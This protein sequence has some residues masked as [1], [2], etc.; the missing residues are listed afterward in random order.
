MTTSSS[1]R[2]SA[3]LEAANRLFE[4][5]GHGKTTIADVAREAHVGVGTVY[6]EF[7]SKEAIVQ[8]LSS[9]AHVA[10]LDAMRAAAE[11]ERE[12][13]ARLAAALA[14]RT[15]CFLDLRS[16]GQHACELVFCKTDSVRSAHQ[17]F[18]EEE[19][20]LLADI[21]ADGKKSGAFAPCEPS[22][23]A[24]LVQRAFASLSPPWIFGVDEDA[25]RASADLCQLLLHGLLVKKDPRALLAGPPRVRAPKSTPR[26][27]GRKPPRGR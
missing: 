2:R 4:H 13:P 3:I 5:Y 12:A 8:E 6:L 19:R 11:T 1:D 9:G 27:A 22:A 14:A 16:K 24:S 23:V 10:V 25:H 7:E 15:R 26:P 17:R 21:V 18:K 20:A